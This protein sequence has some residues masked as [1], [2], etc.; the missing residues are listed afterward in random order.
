MDS[1]VLGLFLLAA[2]IG[3]VV[4]GLSGFAMSLVVSGIW[5]HILSPIQTI[6][7]L[8]G[9][10]LLVQGYGIWKLRHAL[11]WR[12]V[13]PFIVGGV[14]GVPIGVW[15]LTYINPSSMRT[16]VGSLILIYSVYGLARPTFKPVQAGAFA[17]LGVGV[18][19]GLLGGLTGFAGIVVVIWCQLRGL[20]KDVQRSVSQP[21][22]FAAFAIGAM[23]LG[24][25]GQISAE[26]AILYAYGL[27]IVAAGIWVGFKLYGKLDDAAFR[28]VVLLLL[29]LAGSGLTVP[30]IDLLA[31]GR[32]FGLRPN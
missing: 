31:I 14:F 30:Q 9:Y 20:P 2:F 6:T 10:G 32:Q 18:L 28:K 25:K 15:L 1:T 3:G 23:T 24:I 27:P 7:L 4:N 26:T 12:M 29:L 13:A 5:L 19:N 21:V 16:V 11:D 17:D 22:T 8:V